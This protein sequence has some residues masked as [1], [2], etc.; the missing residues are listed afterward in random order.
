[1]VNK[2][3]EFY[4][5]YMRIIYLYDY[6]YF[7]KNNLRCLK[8]SICYSFFVLVN[9]ILCLV[10]CIFIVR[11][12]SIIILRVLKVSVYVVLVNFDEIDR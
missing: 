11:I 5:V 7:F 10:S 1:M 3:N 9:L 12:K 4:G 2:R 6:I 8:C